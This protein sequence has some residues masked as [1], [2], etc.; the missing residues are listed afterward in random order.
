MWFV[1]AS[2]MNHLGNVAPGSALM[3]MLLRLLTL[4]FA[5]SSGFLEM[6]ASDSS[7]RLGFGFGMNAV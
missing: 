5:L 2:V 7:C 4:T 6:M 3:K 1:A